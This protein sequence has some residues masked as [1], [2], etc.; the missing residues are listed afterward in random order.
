IPQ[1]AGSNFNPTA[2]GVGPTGAFSASTLN[3]TTFNV[4]ANSGT[5]GTRNAFNPYLLSWYDAAQQRNGG[6][7]TVDQRLTKDISFYGEGFYSD[8]RSE[9]LNPSTLGPVTTDT[10]NAFTVPTWNPYYPT[11]GAPNNL[12]VSYDLGWEVPRMTYAY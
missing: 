6:A 1:G 4:A 3:W 8:R 7:I 10:L 5:N 11:G 9:Y 12:R 2:S